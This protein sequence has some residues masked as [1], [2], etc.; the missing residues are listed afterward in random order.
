MTQL[1]KIAPSILA[2]DFG[3]LAD[4]VAAVEAGGADWI[5]ID[6]MD[7]HFVPN[8]TVGP[9]IVQAIRRVTTLPLD[10]HLMI[11]NPDDY[12]SEF[13]DAGADML[14]VHLE[15]C[16]HL[17]RTVQAIK[18]FGAKAGVALNPATDLGSLE[19]ILSDLDLLLIMSVNPGFGG[20]SFIPSIMAKIRK[21]RDLIDDKSLQI[22]LEV[23]GGLSPDNAATVVHAG[24]T[25]LV[26]G[27]AI[28]NA[29][30]YDTIIHQMR[31]AGI[32]A[33]PVETQRV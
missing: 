13:C 16:P 8:I 15:T 28:F 11:T 14:T 21:A 1:V 4:E 25:V 30:K 10:V 20:Q 23:D 6:V 31:Q 33:M 5:H 9:T 17:H 7:G 19:E 3:R 22:E 18:G 24:A 32:G 27:S 2:A 26:A 29:P 12:L